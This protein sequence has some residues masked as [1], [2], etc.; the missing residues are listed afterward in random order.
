M[1]FDGYNPMTRL[2]SRGKIKNSEPRRSPSSELHR[3]AN[4]DW[5]AKIAASSQRVIDVIIIRIIRECV[6]Q[7]YA[8]NKETCGPVSIQ[9]SSAS[10]WPYH[11]ECYL[12]LR[13]SKLTLYTIISC[14][15]HYSLPAICLFKISAS[16]IRYLHLIYSCLQHS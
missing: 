12:N 15:H 4:S 13:H 9:I 7:N 14:L 8:I 2:I 16:D 11:P 3:T 1:A 6:R 10:K 5:T